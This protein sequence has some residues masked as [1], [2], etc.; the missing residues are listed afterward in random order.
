[1]LR[2]HVLH[3]NSTHQYM[4]DHGIVVTQHCWLILSFPCDRSTTRI[5]SNLREYP[6]RLEGAKIF[7]VGLGWKIIQSFF[8]GNPI[9]MPIVRQRRP[10]AFNL[11]PI[12]FIQ[13]FSNL[14]SIVI[15][16]QSFFG[17]LLFVLVCGFLGSHRIIPLLDLLDTILVPMCR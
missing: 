9:I 15:N 8:R 1:M 5:G 7:K 4:G 3:S 13:G 6:C 2:C 14:L 16:P 12:F 10:R 11:H 17:R